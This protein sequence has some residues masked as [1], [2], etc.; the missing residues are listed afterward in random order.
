MR[1]RTEDRRNARVGAPADVRSQPA[2]SSLPPPPPFFLSTHCVLPSFLAH[3]RRPRTSDEAVDCVVVP[4]RAEAAP[5]CLSVECRP[6]RRRW[7][8]LALPFF[9]STLLSNCSGG[10][11]LSL[12][13]SLLC[14]LDVDDSMA[15]RLKRDDMASDEVDG[16]TNGMPASLQLRSEEPLQTGKAVA[17]RWMDV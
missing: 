10:L 11:S 13:Y 17:G 5:L 6:A 14:G 3:A 2:A 7:S 12:S 4:R 15:P 8:G 9:P 1:Q 16:P